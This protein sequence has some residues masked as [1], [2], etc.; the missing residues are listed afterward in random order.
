MSKSEA[1]RA[2]AVEWQPGHIRGAT[3]DVPVR[4]FR[5]SAGHSGWLVWAHGGSWHGGSVA[6][7]H[8]P[9][10]DL[11]RLSGCA[12]VSVEYRLAPDDP[13]PAALN[14]VLTALDWAQRKSEQEGLPAASVGGDSAGGTVA[15]CAAV[16]RRDQ[17]RPLT[18]Q[19]L[20][21]PPF[22]PSCRA[23]S[24]TRYEGNFPTRE[25]LA[26]AWRS[27][28]SGASKGSALPSTPFEVDD[29]SGLAPAIL[30]VGEFDAVADDVR[31]YADRLR[32]AGN[33]LEFQEF[34]QMAHGAFLQPSAPGRSRAG[35]PSALRPWLGAALRRRYPSAAAAPGLAESTG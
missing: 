35:G 30:G 24:Y 16:V 15:A 4:V 32:E 29:L 18:A 26:G 14:D 34:P 5:P 23:P 9:C 10:A 20:A 11:S 27:Y 28:R 6:G 13:H 3:H 22:D 17:G 21:Y 2:R 7:W 19:V 31:Q 25:G 8:R 33:D 12:V 1:P